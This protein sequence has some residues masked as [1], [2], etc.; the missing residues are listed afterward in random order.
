MT[1]RSNLG[2]RLKTRIADGE[3]LIGAFVPAPS[4]ELVEIAA[5]S[6]FDFVVVDAEHGPLGPNEAVQMI[7][8]AQAAMLPVLLRVPL[9]SKD[10]VLRALD[11]GVDGVIIPQVDTAADAQVAVAE[12]KYP[13]VGNRGAAF[14]TRAH[15][16]TRD[17]GWT[18]LARANDETIVAV[19]AESPSAMENL[20][21][22][23][24][25]PGVDFVLYGQSDLSVC[26]GEGPHHAGAM[27]KAYDTITGLITSE[28]LRAGI[29]AAD[30]N[31][32]RTHLAAGFQ[33]IVTGLLPMLLKQASQFVHTVHETS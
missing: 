24:Q 27:D 8:A 7:R 9:A 5:Y 11:C 21:A 12:C 15:R 18:S 30:V 29:S 2:K 23:A 1:E 14:Y 13:P 32:A 26:I 20:P 4:P 16:F 6:D 25:V 33:I 28:Q 19:I 22:I 3:T 31:A 17:S 10:H